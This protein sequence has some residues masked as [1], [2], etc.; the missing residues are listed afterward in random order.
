MTPVGARRRRSSTVALRAIS[1]LVTPSALR[2]RPSIASRPFIARPFGRPTAAG[3]L[4]LPAPAGRGPPASHRRVGANDNGRGASGGCRAP[5]WLR[6]SPRRKAA[7]GGQRTP[8]TLVLRG[9]A[10]G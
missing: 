6:V 9:N 4:R 3:T 2:I 1:W 7:D 10:S 5:A 8:T